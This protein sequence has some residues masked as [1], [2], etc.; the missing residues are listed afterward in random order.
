SAD[1]HRAAP[2][3]LERA[4]AGHQQ[5]CRDGASPSGV[6]IAGDGPGAPPR[7]PSQRAARAEGRGGHASSAAGTGDA[8]EPDDP[9]LH[10]GA[11]EAA[12][13]L[14]GSAVPAGGRRHVSQPR[15]VLRSSEQ[16]S[17]DHQRQRHWDPRQGKS[18]TEL[19]GHRRMHGDDVRAGGR[20]QGRPRRWARGATV[21]PLLI[22]LLMLGQA[23]QAPAAI[24]AA[25][26]ASAQVSAAQKKNSEALEP[27]PQAPTTSS[28]AAPQP[29]VQASGAPA[30]ST[31][32]GQAAEASVPSSGAGQASQGA[33]TY[34]PSGRRDP[35]VSLL[36]GGGETR[37]SGAS[38]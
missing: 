17:S 16:V 15:S 36:L 14:R 28:Q 19:H 13:A 38:R 37:P 33:Y 5:G 4:E 1:R 21:M 6:R 23:A 3:A 9:A 11:A 22:A 24:A 32:P 8:V 35:F 20:G 2:D 31:S 10:G 7:E 27:H 29:G 34:D 12:A 25:K 30:L 26:N 18:R